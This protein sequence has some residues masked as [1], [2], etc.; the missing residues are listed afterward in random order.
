MV[1]MRAIQA[2]GAGGVHTTH[3]VRCA[4]WLSG[5]PRAPPSEAAGPHIARTA[6]HAAGG[7]A[8]VRMHACVSLWSLVL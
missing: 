5:G 6:G 4:L 3:A 7:A 2:R 1:Y 8:H